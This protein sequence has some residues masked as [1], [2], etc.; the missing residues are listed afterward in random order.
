M[1]RVC[2]IKPPPRAR[3]TC[4]AEGLAKSEGKAPIDQVA[5]V[6][7]APRA[8]LALRDLAE[9]ERVRKREAI[10]VGGRLDDSRNSFG[11]RR[12]LLDEPAREQPDHVLFVPEEVR[13]TTTSTR[14]SRRYYL[15]LRSRCFPRV[16]GF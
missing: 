15:E 8:L 3:E 11:S 12:G 16:I 9:S 14:D 1:P 5:R 7:K 10:V 4:A 6:E 13:T 2:C